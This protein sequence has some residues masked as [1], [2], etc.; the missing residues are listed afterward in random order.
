[1][2]HIVVILALLFTQLSF[3]VNAPTNH[4]AEFESRIKVY[5]D[6]I[7][8]K[9]TTTLDF[10][11]GYRDL[12][13]AL[14]KELNNTYKMLMSQLNK[15]EKK[16]LKQSQRQWIKY[17]DAEFKFIEK[18]ITR[19]QFGS[20]FILLAGKQRTAILKARVMALLWYLNELR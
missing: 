6:F 1:M 17:R 2:K 20:S 16:T 14:D 9:A 5:E 7:S 15:S 11:D 12:Y 8:K 10:S 18:T 4:V 13:T 3:A 19:D